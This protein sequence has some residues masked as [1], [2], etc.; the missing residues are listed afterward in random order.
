MASTDSKGPETRGQEDTI[1]IDGPSSIMVGKEITL[2]EEDA[3]DVG[4]QGLGV[5]STITSEKG[6]SASA[7]ASALDRQREDVAD[8]AGIRVT[9]SFDAHFTPP[10]DEPPKRRCTRRSKSR[11]KRSISIR[12]HRYPTPHSTHT[13]IHQVCPFVSDVTPPRSAWRDDYE[14]F[15]TN[16]LYPPPSLPDTGSRPSSP[17]QLATAEELDALWRTSTG[18]TMDEPSLGSIVNLKLSKTPRIDS[19]TYSLGN[20]SASLYQLRVDFS[21]VA[22]SKQRPH[23]RRE[24]IRNDTAR[25]LQLPWAQINRP[26]RNR[27]Y[28]TDI[29]PLTVKGRDG[30]NQG[31]NGQGFLL[32]KRDGDRHLSIVHS[33]A[34]H[35]TTSREDAEA[36]RL[37]I[38]R[39]SSAQ[40]SVYIPELSITK[41]DTPDEND[42]T[43]PTT[44]HHETTAQ[45][46]PQATTLMKLDLQ[47]NILTIN[48]PA[49]NH[50]LPTT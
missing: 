23:L 7:S 44:T 26:E 20:E 33:G 13:S 2:V 34:T 22:V 8:L 50:A 47:T 18:D 21:G 40:G 6:W 30:R 1:D 32:V 48:L 15:I 10:P 42:T 36:L 14:P 45:H 25:V 28:V 41:Q 24:S 12:R 35:T 3:A 27:E 17:A 46:E 38:E 19:S 5:R 39:S 16:A 49:I 9:N 43:D 4:Y 11:S 37:T 29:T 31:S